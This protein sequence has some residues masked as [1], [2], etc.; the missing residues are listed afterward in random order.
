MIQLIIRWVLFALALICI[1]WIVP[2]IT[3][4]SFMTALWTALVIGLVNIFIRPVL[5]ILTLPINLLTLG[6][7]TLFING[8]M[9]WMVATFVDGF[10]VSGF[11]AAF[12]G[13]LM[14]SVLSL[15]INEI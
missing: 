6:L 2:G 12:F 1:A 14:L 10:A 4:D 8:L 5:L 15:F 11:L 9:F 7:L 3:L 13:A